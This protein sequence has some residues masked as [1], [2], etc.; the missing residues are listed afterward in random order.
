MK[1]AFVGWRGMVGSVLLN[2]IMEKEDHLKHHYELFS[3]SQAGQNGP[4]V[5]G[6]QFGNLLDAYNTEILKEFDVILT[7]QGSDY[8]N[9][10]Y[11]DATYTCSITI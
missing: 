2:R 1:V 7:C 8:T 5:N 10:I 6:Y 3:T 11:S 4:V 9:K